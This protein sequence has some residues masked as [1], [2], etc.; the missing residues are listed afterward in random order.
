MGLIRNMLLGVI[1]ILAGVLF[2]LATGLWPM[3]IVLGAAIILTGIYLENWIGKKLEALRNKNPFS[4]KGKEEVVEYSTGSIPN[5][6][7]PDEEEIEDFERSTAREITSPLGNPILPKKSTAARDRAVKEFMKRFSLDQK[8]ALLL[9]DNGYSS[10]SDFEQATK[11]D[12][13]GIDGISPTV[14]R[15]I[16]EAAHPEV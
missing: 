9:F 14:A 5:A 15:R 7:Y 11:E 3:G 8:R 12:I 16:I 10:F 13:A 6:E 2:T 1:A 4:S